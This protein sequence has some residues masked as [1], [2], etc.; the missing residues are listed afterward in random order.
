MLVCVCE[1]VRVNAWW[2]IFLFLN[3]GLASNLC[4]KCA[5]KHPRFKR[6]ENIAG[7]NIT[8][9]SPIVLTYI[10]WPQTFNVN[11]CVFASIFKSQEAFH[12]FAFY[13][14]GFIC[15]YVSC[16]VTTDI[17]IVTSSLF[18]VYITV[19][20]PIVVQIF[21]L[22]LVY[23]CFIILWIVQHTLV[24]DTNNTN[25]YVTYTKSDKKNY[26]LLASMLKLH[27]IAL[28]KKKTEDRKEN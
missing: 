7:V 13:L 19:H 8:H 6:E 16:T 18:S 28:S 22:L 9:K 2:P 21:L 26:I 10:L 23:C 17:F 3:I 15:T 14:D 4:N 5:H 1:C 25:R 20:W 12:C 24:I 11:V 27:H